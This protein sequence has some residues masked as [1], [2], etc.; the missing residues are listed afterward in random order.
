MSKHESDQFGTFFGV[1]GAITGF[2]YGAVITEGDGIASLIMAVI[3]GISGVA[4]GKVV[5]RVILIGLI[6]LGFFLRQQIFAAIGVM[7]R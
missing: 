1:I 4:I 5:Y 2:G 6:I 3:G 7:L